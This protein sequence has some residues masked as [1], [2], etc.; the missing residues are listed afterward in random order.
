M[1]LRSG[2]PQSIT[3]YATPLDYKEVLKASVGIYAQDQW[4]VGSLTLNYGARFEYWNS[5]VPPQSA[6][7]GLNVPNRNVS[8]PAVPNVPIWKNLTPRLG[9]SY[10]LFGN[11][12]T[13]IKGSLG[14]FVF[15][16][17]I[18][19]FTRIGFGPYV[20]NRAEP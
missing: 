10:D 13:A 1:T 11:G 19:G 8:Y 4:K 16:P 17:E 9:V 3:E 18:I 2:V 12:K 20:F 7:P 15:G 6:G 5:Y 14:Q